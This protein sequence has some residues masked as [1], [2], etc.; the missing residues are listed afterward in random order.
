M[1]FWRNSVS[2]VERLTY[3]THP[4]VMVSTLGVIEVTPLGCFLLSFVRER[5]RRTFE[6][7]FRC[8]P[9]WNCLTK[10]VCFLHA[11]P[12]LAFVHC[13]VKYCIP[14]YPALGSSVYVELARLHL[15][16]GA[17]SQ[18]CCVSNAPSQAVMKYERSHERS[19]SAAHRRYISKRHV[20]L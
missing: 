14:L 2:N 9:Q 13:E 1:T 7:G 17:C 10:L 6:E 4:A 15:D 16:A 8:F 19:R 3:P 11:M 5:G 20:L 12:T 18:R